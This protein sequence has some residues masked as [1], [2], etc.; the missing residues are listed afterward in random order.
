M[1][2]S[3]SRDQLDTVQEISG[4][5]TPGPPKRAKTVGDWDGSGILRREGNGD[6]TEGRAQSKDGEGG[7]GGGSEEEE[8][9]VTQVDKFFADLDMDYHRQRKRLLSD[10]RVK[11]SGSQYDVIVNY[12]DVTP[13]D[14]S[15]PERSPFPPPHGDGWSQPSPG[16]W[17][18]GRSHQTLHGGHQAG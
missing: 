13:P 10:P 11:A 5:L 3:E 12:S 17:G 2:C 7:E 8:D 4:Y 6:S 9:V 1:D 14:L 18:A 15:S 16:T